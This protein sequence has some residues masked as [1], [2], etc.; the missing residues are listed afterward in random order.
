[1]YLK[2]TWACHLE[3]TS[4]SGLKVLVSDGLKEYVGTLFSSTFTETG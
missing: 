4:E 2:P 1:M 3:I